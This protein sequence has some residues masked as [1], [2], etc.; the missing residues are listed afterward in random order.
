MDKSELRRQ[1]LS[2]LKALSRDD[3]QRHS[4]AISD[5]LTH[6]LTSSSART[7][8][9]FDPLPTE[10]DITRFLED[11]RSSQANVRFCY[12]RC[13]ADHLCFY[14]VSSDDQLLP[15]PGR[16]FREPNPLSCP[17]IS[18]GD[19][20]LILVPGLAFA[21]DGS[22]RLGRGGGFYDRFLALP[23]CRA[24]TIG[25]CFSCQLRKDIPVE[26]HDIPVQYLITEAN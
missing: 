4:L 22:A 18:P 5:A 12:P 21:P 2:R 8:A 13:K 14:E 3:R 25:T 16:N 17:E 15:V 9:V 19:I 20:D 1:S 24:A 6:Y 26:T 7:I 11:A 10:P 23:A